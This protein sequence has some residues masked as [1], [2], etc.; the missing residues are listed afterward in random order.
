MEGVV[1]RVNNKKG[2]GFIDSQGKDYFVHK[3]DIEEKSKLKKGDRV[4][5]KVEK[6]PQDF[7]AIRVRKIEESKLN[8]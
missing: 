8:E 1:K 5:F 2:Y 4:S 6:V 3:W 7:K